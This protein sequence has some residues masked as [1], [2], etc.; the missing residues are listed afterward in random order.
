VDTASPTVTL[1]QP[2]S[3]SNETT[4][5]FTGSASETT[6][7]TVD[8]YA[9][10]TAKGAVVSTATATGTGADWTSGDAGP[11]LS[12]GQYT[13]VAVQQSSLGN[14]A[15]VSSPV[16]FIVDTA[17]PAV[18]LNQPL[19]PSK[20]TTP[21]FT[22]SASE[23]TP[24]AID[25]YAGSTATGPVVSTTTATGTGGGWTSGRASPALSG[26]EYTAVAVQQ[27]SLGNPAGVSSPV[28]FIVDTASP[29][30]TLSQPE[31]L[32]KN[33]APSFTGSASDT[34]PVTVDI[35]AGSTAAGAV[36]STATATGTGGAWTSG[37]ASPSLTSGQYTAVASQ[38]SSLGNPAGV[39][40]PVTF[41]VETASPTVALNQPE[42]PS[43]NTMPSFTGSA[44]D[45]TTVTV[46][47]YAGSTAKGSPVSTATAIGTSVNW[48][49]DDASP[50]LPSG[51][52]TAVASQPSSLGNPAGVSGP[53]T[54]TVE[55]AAPTVTLNAPAARSNDTTPAFTGKASDS[56][57]VTVNIYA[58]ATATGSPVSKAAATR[59]GGEWTSGPASPALTSGQY[60]AVATQESKLGNPAGVSAPMTFT[61]ET[62]SPTV[63]L[64]QPVSPSNNATPS[65]TGTAS[66][67]TAVTVTIYLGVTATGSV[68]AKATATGTGGGWTSGKASPTLPSGQY[69]AVATQPSSVG[70]PAGVSASVTFVVETAA[71]RVTLISPAERSNDQTPSFT[72]TAS[73]TTPVTVQV[74]KGATATGSVVSTATA[75]PSGGVW[76]SGPASP[77]LETNGKYTAIATQPS[78]LGNPAGVSA[79]VTFEVDMSSPTVTLSQPASPSNKTAPSFTG[80][81]SDTTEVTIKVYKGATATGTEV[82]TAKA[83]VPTEREPGTLVTWTSTATSPV[84]ASGQYTAIATEPS[85]FGDPAGLSA[86]V[87]FTVET[88]APKVTLSTPKSPSNDTTPSFTGTA[89]DTTAV[90]IQVYQGATATGTVV[91]T[92][93]ATPSNGGWTSSNASPALTSGQYTAIA[94]QPS[95]LGNASGVSESVTFEVNTSSPTVTL[96]QPPSPSNNTVPSFTGT[97][98]DTAA[99]TVDIYEG[100]TATGSPVSTATAPAGGNWTSGKA[101]PALSDHTY[102]AIA[103]QTSSLGNPPGVS[104]P[105]TF[106]V[107]TK[108]PTLTF[109]KSPPLRSNNAKPSFS[110]S[111]SDTTEV[112]VDIYA[113]TKATGTVVSKA[114][115][116]PIAG[117]WTSDEAN[118]PL[119]SGRYTATATQASSIGNSAGVSANPVQFTVDTEA[120]SVTLSPPK[121]PSND[122]T[123]SFTGIGS[124]TTPVVVHIYNS[125]SLE[126]SKATAPGNGSIWTSGPASP[127]LPNGQ[128]T[129]IASQASSLG[130]HTG[131]S[132]LVTFTVDTVPPDVVLTETEPAGSGS[133]LVKGYAGTEPIDLS[134]VTV[135]LFSGSTIVE[136]QAVPSIT[137]SAPEGKWS[138]TFAG[139]A[140]GTYTARAEQSDKAGNVGVSAPSTFVIGGSGSGATSTQGAAAPAA[141]FTWFPTAPHTG[142]PVSL[143]SSSTDASSPIT[144]LAWD[145]AGDGAF[146]PGTQVMS[147]SFST[148]GNHVVRLRV[149]DANGLSSVAAETIAVTTPTLTLM[150][151]FPIVRIASTDTAA[152]VRIRVLTVQAS[153]GARISVECKG[154]GCPIRAQSRVATTG[155]LG[156]APVAFRRFERSLR[157]GV[158]LEIRIS[159]PGEIGKYTRFVVRRGK[160]PVRV[161]TCLGPVGVNPMT[162]P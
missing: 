119:P 120:P 114:T 155:K 87:T 6:A 159:K 40:G 88:A 2:E 134:V 54:F 8:I 144:T 13:A 92:G 77:A 41:T 66:E 26:G 142:E 89:S 130:N 17:S 128:Y 127:V 81:A 125:T 161:D 16:T 56:T 93:T 84:L 1:N 39:S 154:R 38:P 53:V 57:P 86:P 136:G 12:G 141:S 82:S 138:T 30:V 131:E 4:P 46:D 103:T 99:V 90:T 98:S 123:P 110:G 19:S 28:T 140:P 60:T 146:A 24:V 68:V 95:S 37:H 96:G 71:P 105:V 23:T 18:S 49:S 147:T 5:S 21:S 85:S 44:S 42:S 145:L 160:L 101:S 157:A 124:E 112:T 109:T 135:Q 102:T 43:N 11:A 70:N 149:T 118:P 15:G 117:S 72:G 108:P 63:A 162:C 113:G 36:V 9:G 51:Q 45:T 75:T 91:S 50:A 79:P 129:A 78:S 14:P 62:A 107:D 148:P 20:D 35:Y 69:T 153:G 139:L 126:V 151:P 137:V 52:Y 100:A 65:F 34:T 158:T 55:T 27:S 25:I 150:Q 67:S 115:A 74:Y 121:S 33:T 31:L 111:A 76:T 64:N 104:A 143:A 132:A 94:T 80:T 97:A 10:S 22:G 122:T 152:G 106:T 116:S 59:T 83:T 73:D 61:V 48:V 133:Q 29:T 32:S 7:V 47:I 3:P 156:P 58:G